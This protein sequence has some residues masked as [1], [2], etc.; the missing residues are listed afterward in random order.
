MKDTMKFVYDD[1]LREY[2]EKTGKKTIVVELVQ[3]DNSDFEITELHVHFVDGRMRKK[4]ID[5]RYRAVETDCGEVLLPHFPLEFADTVTF[6]LKKFL[7]MTS[8]SATG[9]KV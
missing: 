4:F 7:F 6:K 2:M 8:I 1:K 5:Q 3:I 9:I